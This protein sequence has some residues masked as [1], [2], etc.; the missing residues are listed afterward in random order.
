M[1]DSLRRRFTRS[2]LYRLVASFLLAVLLW[3]WVGA[4]QDPRIERSY[5]ALTVSS[6]DIPDG[7]SLVSALP[8]VDVKVDGPRSVMG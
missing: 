2:D 4:T 3:G 8:T 6:I 7:L 5:P 1:R